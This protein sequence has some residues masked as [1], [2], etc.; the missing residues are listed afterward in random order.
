MRKILLF[1]FFVSV[2]YSSWG[3]RGCATDEVNQL[4]KSTEQILLE[5]QVF[6]EWLLDKKARLVNQNALQELSE[7]TVYKIP[8]VVHIIHNGEPV[9][10]GLNI[11][12]EQVLS[13]IQVLNK[14]FRHLNPDS[15]NTPDIF[16]PFMADIGFEFVLAKRDPD[17]L[18]TR[19]I[20]RT[21]GY[22]IEWSFRTELEKLKS[23]INWSADDYLNIWVAPAMGDDLG[24]ASLPSS[25]TIQDLNN[26]AENNPLLDGVVV[27]TPAFGSSEFYPFGNYK[28]YFDL[29]RTAT[30]EI[31]HFFGLYHIWGS[32]RSCS[33][34]D[35][36]VDTPKTGY[37]YLAC[38]PAGALYNS[39]TAEPSMFMNYMD[40]VYDGC[41]NLF[42]LGQK[43][44]MVTVINNSP[45]RA[46]LL[47]SP[48][49]DQPPILD[50]T[51][52][53]IVNPES[54]TCVNQIYPA[55]TLRNS[56]TILLTEV[57]LRISTNGL[58]NS[59][60]FY[61]LSLSA[62]QDTM[63]LLPEFSLTQFGNI[64]FTAEIL[65]TNGQQDYFP[66]NNSL[67]KDVFF[68]EIVSAID[69]NFD[70][71]PDSW[72]V[73][74]TAPLSNWNF[75]QAPQE[76]LENKAATL[77]YYNQYQGPNDLLVLPLLDISSYSYPYLVFDHAY[78][79][80]DELDDIL[81]LMVS[82]DCGNTF[83][84]TLFLE[85][86]RELATTQI[87]VRFTPS[88]P[89]DWQTSIIDLSN[90]TSQPIQLAFVGKS[91]GGNNIY[92]DNIHLV[93]KGY[94]DVRI[95]GLLNESGVF[96]SDINSVGLVIENSGTTTLNNLEI[97]LLEDGKHIG[98]QS[99][100]NLNLLPE[101]RSVVYLDNNLSSGVHN[102]QFKLLIDDVNSE[103][104]RLESKVNFLA[105][106]NEIPYR[107]NFD[108]GLSKQ[109]WAASTPFDSNTWQIWQETNNFI[110]YPAQSVG[111][112]GLHDWLVLP[113]FD[114]SNTSLASL[115]Y[116]IAYTANELKN[117]ALRIWL[118]T[119]KGESFDY[120]LKSSSG[121]E[122]EIQTVGID[123]FPQSADDWTSQFI[124]LSGFAGE[125]NI[126]IAFES[127]DGDGGNIYL[128]DIELF[129]SDEPMNIILEVNQMAIY[130]NPVS[131]N[132]THISFRL[133]EKQDL[134]VRVLDANGNLISQQQFL[135]V[136][137]QTYPLD[138]NNL[139]K[140]LYL[141]QV[142]GPS[143]SGVARIVINE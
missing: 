116:K 111:N 107:I 27:H 65:S 61:S 45:R 95:K 122:L 52:S 128:D 22:K 53:A 104:N 77:S 82:F 85:S 89:V 31:G 84:D 3:Q 71:W 30:H 63:L 25:N 4:N 99:W 55:I 14:D 123:W 50:A 92:L 24:F 132:G 127:I 39:C 131:N 103:N 139:A 38:P 120:L 100:G 8:V 15:I 70:S 86:G 17:G 142:V 20:T 57:E 12:E 40:Y 118:S 49:L 129:I 42:T 119:N 137:N 69:E 46:S 98:S 2:G 121:E 91:G 21:N 29:G 72:A 112:I 87:P 6:E 78:G 96:S 62:D 101:G 66:D 7:T 97:E 28:Q 135:N 125:E 19:G 67:S 54:G 37:Y 1:L 16:K 94:A 136:L 133:V 43:E 93:D 108:S 33:V 68:S 110:Y 106:K 74:T 115:Q 56:G 64:A 76:D 81:A 134:Q 34:D 79:Y 126:L 140:G 35:F 75:V 48:A 10:E 80:R 90:Y 141:I 114:F 60:Q 11:S 18:P 23:L 32:S 9:G 113:M 130:P 138:L 109:N 58:E 83:Q 59:R 47:T 5:Q 143:F 73:R 88:G 44:R 102:L 117:E 13:Q 51:I 105:S 36:V 124:D 41:M 26:Y